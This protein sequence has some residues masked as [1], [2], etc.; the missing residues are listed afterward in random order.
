MDISS[1]HAQLKTKQLNDFYIFAGVEWMVQKLYI[2]QIAKIANKPI[3]YID[4]FMDIQN[5]L[6][7]GGIL[8][9]KKVYV[10]RDDSAIMNEEKI[11]VQIK[12]GILS[13]NIL[14]MLLTTV[15]KRKKFYKA[16]KD[17]IVEFEPLKPAILKKYLQKEIK[18]SENNF[19]KLMELCAY[20]Y[21]RCLLEV[22]KI[23]QYEEFYF[24]H[25]S[26]EQITPDIA[27]KEL[28]K[29]GAIYEP[30]KDAIFDFVD[31]V[32][33][34]K[35]NKAYNLYNQCLAVGEA[36]LVMLS[37]LYTN[38]KA[39]LQVQSYEG[40]DMSKGTGLTGWQIKNAMLHTKNY[41]N[42]ELVYLMRQIQ[43]CE[44]GIKTG[45]IDEQF[46]MDYIL[47]DVM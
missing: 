14:V 23:K 4:S 38:A 24:T 26:H 16:Y 43:K 45:R 18:L 13:K 33:D 46:V 12:N 21:G 37:V 30:P 11:Q 36:T 34:R 41:S 44:S 17:T 9:K 7:S 1:L 3:Q 19:E 2:E 27:F 28:L 39:V 31:A 29:E 42:G 25:L 15:D 6:R 47:T 10:V 35:A 22:D 32:L 40:K 20:D 5:K 8:T